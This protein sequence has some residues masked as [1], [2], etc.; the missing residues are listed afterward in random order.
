MEK[1]MNE[2]QRFIDENPNKV[3]V[4]D[5]K[6]KLEGYNEFVAKIQREFVIKNQRSQESASRIILNS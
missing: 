4:I 5:I 2:F 3:E 6:E 1:K